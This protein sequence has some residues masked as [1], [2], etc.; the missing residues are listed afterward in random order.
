MNLDEIYSLAK[1]DS[2]GLH[3]MYEGYL[4]DL[5]GKQNFEVLKTSGLIED[6]GLYNGRKMYA[7]MKSN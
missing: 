5:L 6:K 3:L 2:R 7:W 1:E 4:I